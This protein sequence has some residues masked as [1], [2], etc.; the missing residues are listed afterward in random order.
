M[1][2]PAAPAAPAASPL[3][4][5]TGERT[6]G[7]APSPQIV[8]E[9]TTDLGRVDVVVIG[10]GIVGLAHADIA[11]QQGMTVAVLERDERAVGASLRNF[12]HVCTTAQP[13][14]LQD[15][16]QSSRRG[17]LDAARRHRLPVL[18][19]G[20][21]VL[22][23]RMEAEALLL[24]LAEQRGDAVQMLSAAQAAVATGGLARQDTVTAAARLGADLRTDPRQ[25]VAALAAGLERAGVRIAWRCQV[26]GIEDHGSEVEVRTSAGRIRAGRVICCVGHDLDRLAPELADSQQLRRC[27]L[28]MMRLASPGTRLD[29]A[30]LTTTSML[31][32]GA[33]TELPGYAALRESVL[34]TSPE[35][36]EQVANVMCTQLPD[37]SLI[38]GDSH[39]YEQAT[40][41][42][43]SADVEELLR[44]EM[45]RLLDVGQLRVIERW[46]GVY[47]DSPATDLIDVALSERV[48]VVT[49][50]SGIGMT[51]SFG[52]AARTFAS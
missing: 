44:A 42:F 23:D 45:A 14:A 9:P 51:L 10:A 28:S 48:Q 35:L 1:H 46:Q 13:Q 15:L 40:P 36:V 29:P 26:Q 24:D 11:A 47:A 4:A 2:P 21:V 39:H 12:G 32:Y 6:T 33:F 7:Q 17:W 41:P 52:L 49:V 34:A 22:A 25:A 19:H 18:E 37:G 5:Q 38:L 16:A 20:T 31:R 50:A 3:G 8:G 27:R 43:L 30:V